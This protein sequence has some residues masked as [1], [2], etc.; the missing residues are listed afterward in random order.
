MTGLWR[1]ERHSVNDRFGKHLIGLYL[2]LLIC[3]VLSFGVGRYGLSPGLMMDI[4]LSRLGLVT[5]YWD[6]TLEIVLL[7]VRL[8]RI[9]LAILVGGALAVSG[10]SYQTLFKNPMVSPGILG[11]SAGAGFGAALAMLF[12]AVWWQIQLSA[13][14]FGLCA[15]LMAYLIAWIFGRQELTVMILGG[16]VVSSLF[17]ALLSIVKLFADTDNALPSIVFWLMGSLGRGS[18]QDVLIMLPALLISLL[19]LYLFRYPINTLSAGEDE[20]TTLGTN[21]R[22]VKVLVV[23]AATLM[24]VAAVSISG[25]VGWVGLVVPHIARMLVGA[26]YPRLI[27]SSFAIGGLG[28]LLIDSL[29]RGIPGVELPLGVMTALIGTPIFVLMLSQVRRGWL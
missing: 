17:G 14:L 25:I 23:I 28:L 22:Q 19:L 6:P 8:P 2:C 20:A 16:V 21:V 3:T 10:T 4:A 26:S 29:I 13:F 15:V 5:P 9:L 24:T 7:E 11:V 27:A 1:S 18:N 12:D